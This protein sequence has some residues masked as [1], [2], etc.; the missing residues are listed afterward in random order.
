M[1]DQNIGFRSLAVLINQTD[2]QMKKTTLFGNLLIAAVFTAF[3]SCESTPKEEAPAEE[4]VE[5]VEE[6]AEEAVEAVE[7]AAEAVD[8]TATEAAEAVEEATEGGE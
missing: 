7:E 8:S 6:T 5:A 3:V 4:A 2:Y 1:L